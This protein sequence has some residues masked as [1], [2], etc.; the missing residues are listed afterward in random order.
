MQKQ[1]CYSITYRK[2]IS[3]FGGRMHNCLSHE[4]C[5]EEAVNTAESLCK[6]RGLRFTDLRRKVLE[7]VWESHGPAK[8]YDILDKLKGKSWSAKPPTVYRALDFLLQNGFVHKLSSINAFIGC[9]HPSKHSQCY[10][11]ICSHCSDV[12]ECCNSELSDAIQNTGGK[13]NF[14]PQQITLEIAGKCGDCI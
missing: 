8:A 3:F 14:I 12:K 10:F 2:S 9:S 7:M 1:K 6:D 4:K 13:N 11:L 5:I